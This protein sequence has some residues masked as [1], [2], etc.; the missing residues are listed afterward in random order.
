LA[1]LLL[2]RAADLAALPADTGRAHSAATVLIDS[3]RPRAVAVRRAVSGVS[4]ATALTVG[5]DLALTDAR[6]AALA[7]WTDRLT[8]ATVLG[9]GAGVQTP[10]AA[11]RLARLATR[12]WRR[13]LDVANPHGG[14]HHT[15]QAS[16]KP[17]QRLTPRH[18][19]GYLARQIVKPLIH[20]RS[21]R[22]IAA[23][24]DPARCAA[25][26]TRDGPGEHLP[27]SL[28]G[29][30]YFTALPS[31]RQFPAPESARPFHSRLGPKLRVTSDRSPDGSRATMRE[32]IHAGSPAPPGSPAEA[33]AAVPDPRLPYGRWPERELPRLV[34]LLQFTVAAIL[35]GAWSRYAT[36]QRSRAGPRMPWR[37]A[38]LAD[39]P[40][41]GPPS[42][43]GQVAA[44][45]R[46]AIRSSPAG[47]R[48]TQSCD[49]APPLAG[50]CRWR[51]RG[52]PGATRPRAGALDER[53][54]TPAVPLLLAGARPFSTV[55][56]PSGG[57][58]LPRQRQ[59]V[60]R[61]GAGLDGRGRAA[62]CQAARH[63]GPAR[64]GRRPASV[65]VAPAAARAHRL[66]RR[67]PAAVG[68]RSGHR[69]RRPHVGDSAEARVSTVLPAHR[70]VPPTTNG[71][72]QASSRALLSTHGSNQRSR[73]DSNPRSRP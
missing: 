29:V 60:D 55:G 53:R 36:A 26:H 14:Q 39:A 5:R 21:F 38:D 4:A 50:G 56:A 40:D 49:R 62:A 43:T 57:P 42:G 31:R 19:A 22:A 12:R 23:C 54:C 28:R 13:G 27:Y 45:P 64:N 11:Q 59:V 72:G 68:R 70:A 63:V 66:P 20:L 30:T 51:P 16:T 32:V 17:P 65:R 58:G 73:G 69:Q 8:I 24:P 71:T 6:G 34:R 47:T 33:L 61:G 1:A 15:R 2:I 41:H 46:L 44:H 52:E 18:A 3:L 7:G 25:A 48:A 37:R 35:C 67:A 10:A 9:I